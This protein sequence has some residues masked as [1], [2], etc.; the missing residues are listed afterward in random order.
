[1]LIVCQQLG[2]FKELMGVNLLVGIFSRLASPV[3]FAAGVVDF[4]RLFVPLFRNVS[5]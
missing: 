2:V 3:V 5:L 1:L 4:G